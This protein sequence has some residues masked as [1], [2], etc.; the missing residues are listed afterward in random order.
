MSRY[1]SRYFKLSRIPVVGDFLKKHRLAE[2]IVL[3]IIIVIYMGVQVQ[4]YY[5]RKELVDSCTVT[6]TGQ[7]V[8]TQS[9]Y[10]RHR[11]PQYRGVVEFEVDGKKYTAHTAWQKTALIARK[12]LTVW[13]DPSDPSRNCTDDTRDPSQ[14][15][16]GM[17]MLLGLMLV[18]DIIIIIAEAKRRSSVDLT[19]NSAAAGGG[20]NPYSQPKGYEDIFK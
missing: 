8:D 10:R 6:V 9:K 7:I 19:G 1:S 14:N 2:M 4:R 17:Q 5:Q 11:G 12:P 20:D 13:Y 3:G 15:L 18:I 16:V